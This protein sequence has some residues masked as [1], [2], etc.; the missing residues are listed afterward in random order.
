[1]ARVSILMPTHNRGPTIEGAIKSCLAQK[2]KDWELIIY[3]DGSDIEDGYAMLK[4]KMER[5]GPATKDVIRKYKEPRIKYHYE[6][7]NK[8][9]PHARNAL[10]KLA[11]SDLCCW[12]DSDDKSNVYRLL[13]QTEA[14]DK[15]SPPYIR[16]ATTTFGPPKDLVWSLPPLLVWRG[17]VSFATIMFQRKLAPQFDTRI[18]FCGEDME[19]ECH[20]AAKAGKGM[21]IPLTLYCIGRRTPRRMSMLHKEDEFKDRYN[22]SMA[23]NKKMQEKWIHV[24]AEKGY[25]KMPRPVP[26]E[27]LEPHM[28]EWYGRAY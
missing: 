4:G 12:L 5:I 14:M 26:W 20:F 11:S 13:L 22:K 9:I 8:G 7:Q 21:R 10:L 3:D 6:A 25:E 1:M 27:F 18:N 24:M 19:W 2:F 16:S 28:K 23:V 15:Y 17:G